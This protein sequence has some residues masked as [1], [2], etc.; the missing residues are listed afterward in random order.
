MEE[1][2][3]ITKQADEKVCSFISNTFMT[4]G[5]L[6]LLMNTYDIL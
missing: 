6:I 1:S 3:T 4:I 2:Y 5:Y